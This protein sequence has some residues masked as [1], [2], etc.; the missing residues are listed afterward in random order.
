LKKI[1]LI[2]KRKKIY[3]NNFKKKI[4]RRAAAKEGYRYINI[5]EN[6]LKNLPNNYE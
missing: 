3:F 6:F 2:L 5:S 4:C 1:F